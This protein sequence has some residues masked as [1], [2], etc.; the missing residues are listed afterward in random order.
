MRTGCH[1][2]ASGFTRGL[3]VSGP[4]EG[5]RRGWRILLTSNPRTRTSYDYQSFLC[6][7]DT[8]L[9][10]SSNTSD[11]FPQRFLNPECCFCFI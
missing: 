6:L 2:L 1:P 11:T 4:V 3:E 7:N 10:K 5:R 9:L 8:V